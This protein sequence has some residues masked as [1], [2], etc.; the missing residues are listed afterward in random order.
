MVPN[1]GAALWT[2]NF[3][4]T[5]LLARCTPPRLVRFPHLIRRTTANKIITTPNPQ[6]RV[7]QEDKVKK[8]P[9]QMV[10]MEMLF[11]KILLV[12]LK[13]TC[14]IEGYRHKGNIR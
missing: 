6:I 5:W 14:K 11:I 4:P 12:K 13:K 2:L 3:R 8:R 9:I 1:A 7:S 10:G